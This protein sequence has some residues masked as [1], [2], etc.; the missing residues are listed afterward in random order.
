MFHLCLHYLLILW[1]SAQGGLIPVISDLI[2]F[3]YILHI[4]G[5]L[6]FMK[7]NSDPFTL[8]HRNAIFY[9]IKSYHSPL[10]FMILETPWE[11]PSLSLH[12]LLLPLFVPIFIPPLHLKKFLISKIESFRIL[13]MLK[14]F[15]PP[16]Y[17]PT[18]NPVMTKICLKFHKNNTYYTKT[19]LTLPP[20]HQRLPLIIF[21]D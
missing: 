3:L 12:T 8:L 9:W 6:M 11:N 2:M 21:F 7:H 16:S 14:L 20:L 1:Q 19:F 13:P 15:I 5:E 17:P 18:S 10:A 4:L